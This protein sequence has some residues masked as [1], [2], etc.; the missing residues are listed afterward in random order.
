MIRRFC[1]FLLLFLSATYVRADTGFSVWVSHFIHGYHALAIPFMEYDYRE[2]FQHIPDESSLQRQ[3]VFF[4]DKDRELQQISRDGL[5]MEA[6]VQYDHIRYEIDFHLRR[7]ILE[8]DWVADG[9]KIP[10]GGLFTLADHEAWYALFIQKF[11]GLPLPAETV[12]QYGLEEVKRVQHEIRRIRLRAGFADSAAFYA[13]LSDSSFFM[14][15]REEVQQAFALTDQLVRKQLKKFVGKL[16]LPVVYA[17][18]WPDAHANTPP[19]MYLNHQDNPYGKDVFQYNFFGDRY[20]RRAIEWLYMHEAIPG[21]HLQFCY[22]LL[23]AVDSLCFLTLY[24]G[25]FEGWACYVEYEGHALGLYTDWRSELGKWEWDL[26]R[27]ARLVMETGIHQYGW[28][29]EKAL[30]YWKA[31]IPGQDDIA[32][33]EVTRITNWPGQSLTYKVGADL[34]YELKAQVKQKEGKKFNEVKFHR[35]YL[36]FGRRPLEV[37]RKNFERM[38]DWSR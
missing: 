8:R 24:P 25:N 18:E 17:M 26:V 11:T 33:R 30:A 21:H 36:N 1:I 13:Y 27:S 7:I 37:V 9:R 16:D 6:Q 2:Y 10:S 5:D 15:R 35:A 28:S 23:L 22:E 12:M 4:R 34:I 31:N 38:Y 14:Y 20:N 32:E 19:G 29:R 3:E